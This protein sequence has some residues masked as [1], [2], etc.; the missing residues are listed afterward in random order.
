MYIYFQWTDQECNWRKSLGGKTTRYSHLGVVKALFCYVNL[1][2]DDSLGGGG[3]NHAKFFI[4]GH[5]VL[6]AGT[7]LGPIYCLKNGRTNN[8]LATKTCN[9]YIRGYSK[10]MYLYFDP[11]PQYNG[12][13]YSG[14]YSLPCYATLWHDTPLKTDFYLCVS[15]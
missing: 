4:W 1:Q 8:L 5:C 2:V 11:T 10:S 13:S 14:S 7:C 9:N 3:Q 12:L 15:I 6:P